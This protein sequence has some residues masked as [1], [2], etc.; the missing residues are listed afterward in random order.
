MNE[1]VIVG[2][3]ALLVG[4]AVGALVV[5][6]LDLKWWGQRVQTAVKERNKTQATLNAKHTNLQTTEKKLLAARR[7]VEKTNGRLEDARDEHQ[8]VCQQLAAS[9]V[10]IKHLQQDL[11]EAQAWEQRAAGLQTEKTTLANQLEKTQDQVDDLED[12]IEGALKQVVETQ[13]LRKK[14]IEADE[15]LETADSQIEALQEKLTAVQDQM[16]YSGKNQLQIIRG[17]G[18]AYA[19]RLNEA[20]VKTLSDLAEIDPEKIKEIIGLKP[21]QNVETADWV[22]EAKALTIKIVDNG[23]NGEEP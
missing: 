10:E 12:Q 17:I 22:R 11:E 21:W 3:L 8:A 1:I 13:F 2:L 16:Q 9:E 23:D 4:L 18:P 5:L 15:K 20:G 19:R 6:S 7:E 14:L